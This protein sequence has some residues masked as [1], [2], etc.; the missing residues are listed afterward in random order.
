VLEEISASKWL[1]IEDLANY[2]AILIQFIDLIQGDQDFILTV[3]PLAKKILRKIIFY[4][5]IHDVR[6]S[7]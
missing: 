4:I 7:F 1:F 5:K 6:D 2:L 3:M